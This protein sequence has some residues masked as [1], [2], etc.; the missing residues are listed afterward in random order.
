MNTVIYPLFPSTQ[1]EVNLLSLCIRR[2]A[3][4]FGAG[5]TMMGKRG[6]QVI[7]C[8]NDQMIS[9]YASGLG[10]RI[11]RMEEEID[12]N[13][14]P[15]PS[16]A[17]PAIE[18]CKRA[19]LLIGGVVLLDYRHLGMSHGEVEEAMSKVERDNSILVSILEPQDHPVQF[20]IPMER[21]FTETHMRPDTS[22]L[23]H[24]ECQFP[25][26]AV[27]SSPFFFNWEQCGIHP[28]FGQNLAY[29]QKNSGLDVFCEP[30]DIETLGPGHDGIWLWCDGPNSARRL[31]TDEDIRLLGSDIPTFFPFYQHL[32]ETVLLIQPDGKNR[33]N[34]YGQLHPQE[35]YHISTYRISNG[36]IDGQPCDESWVMP[37][38]CSPRQE[39]IATDNGL[40]MQVAFFQE[41]A[42]DGFF[43]VILRAGD[44]GHA[45]HFLPFM[46]ENGGWEINAKTGQRILSKNGLLVSGRQNFPSVYEVDGALVAMTQDRISDFCRFPECPGIQGIELGRES[47]VK[48]RS[49]ID[50][51]KFGMN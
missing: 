21:A 40:F 43:L 6:W 35:T 23:N 37:E 48:V 27:A 26:K 2:K 51:L 18:Y 30:A 31:I 14:G 47:C 44:G 12:L 34:I 9:D 13:S 5:R 49:E 15:L 42:V 17:L 36:A 28:I 39:E 46:L 10:L 45:T 16:G 19:G 3:P 7:L 22:F 38:G 41:Q 32:K 4:L 20:D 50:L 11:V 29:I 33:Y 24:M 25:V 8:T 1:D